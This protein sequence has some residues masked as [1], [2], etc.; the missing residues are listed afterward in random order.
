MFS[1]YPCCSF[2]CFF[3]WRWRFI[4]VPSCRFCKETVWNSERKRFPYK[5]WVSVM[6]QNPNGRKC[7]QTRQLNI[8]THPSKVANSNCLPWR[9][10]VHMI[11]EQIYQCRSWRCLAKTIALH[12]GSSWPAMVI[13][14]WVKCWSYVPKIVSFNMGVSKN[15]V[16]PKSS[17]LRGFSITNHPFWDTPIFGKYPYGFNLPTFQLHGSC[18]R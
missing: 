11:R 2:G 13:E 1:K 8:N 5:W 7:E 4:H 16:I 17:I 18:M 14:N 10:H 12:S 9:Y 15:S 6:N 3:G